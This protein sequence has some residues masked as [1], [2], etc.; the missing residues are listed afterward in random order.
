MKGPTKLPT[1]V[2]SRSPTER[3]LNTYVALCQPLGTHRNCSCHRWIL[4]QRLL[5]KVALWCAP[6]PLAAT[7]NSNDERR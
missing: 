3:E 2:F 4:L 7:D 6:S 1:A 5:L